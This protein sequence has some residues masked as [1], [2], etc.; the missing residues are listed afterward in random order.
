MN[1]NTRF[2]FAS[3][4][5]L[6]LLFVSSYMIIAA[7][8]IP[9]AQHPMRHGTGFIEKK[10]NGLT[11]LHLKG[12]AYERGYQRGFL[13][14]DQLDTMIKHD[15]T[16]VAILSGRGDLVKGLATIRELAEINKPFI[17][18]NI[19]QEIKGIANGLAARGSN[20]TYDDILLHAISDDIS[21]MDLSKPLDTNATMTGFPMT[22]CSSF[23]AFG[24]ATK[25]GQLIFGANED[26]Y[27]TEDVLRSRMAIVVDPTD[28]G[29]GYTG[30]IWNLWYGAGGMNEA[31]IAIKAHLSFSQAETLRGVVTDM[32][33]SIVLQYADSIEDAV[34][35]L[36]SHPRTC[37]LIVHVADG[38][39]NRAAVIEYTAHDIAVRFPEHGKD[40]L[41]STNHFNCYPG[42][43]GY[44]GVNMAAYNANRVISGGK[45]KME[46]I[47]T[48]EKWQD[49]L[50]K[51]GIGRN[52]RYGRYQQLL[53]QNYGKMT[54]EE[55]KKLLRDRYDIKTGKVISLNNP[56]G[57]LI[58][59]Y[60]ADRIMS[61][62]AIPYKSIRSGEYTVKSGTVFSFV[63]TPGNGS[64]WLAVGNVPPVNYTAGYKYMNL[65]E[66]LKHNR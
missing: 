5:R 64:I 31:G 38:K 12:T 32:L 63:S 13:L 10:P 6:A 49:S 25:D 29:Y 59:A 8:Q 22:R 46:D 9:G 3:V 57:E 55:A 2:L 24:T 50:E 28:G 52:G 47:S 45:G 33:L 40:I 16:Q 51:R 41:W 66:E 42:W 44:T 23:S 56:V 61:K 48:V 20:L 30:G 62:N 18:N 11:V 35:I 60:D 39:T 58:C 34:D 36:A 21:M 65:R 53:N 1:N 26:Y 54:I 43:Q 27:D 4:P 37:G 17:P 15:L 7:A 19:R 14:G